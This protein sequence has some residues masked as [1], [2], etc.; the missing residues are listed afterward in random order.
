MRDSA[1][2]TDDVLRVLDVDSAMVETDALDDL[3]DLIHAIRAEAYAAGS[4]EMHRICK[5]TVEECSNIGSAS[6]YLSK[7]RPLAMGEH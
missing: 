7:L 3:S 2:I 1:S 6:R 4:A 5:T